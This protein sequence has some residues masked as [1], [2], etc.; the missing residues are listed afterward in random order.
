MRDLFLQ[1]VSVL[2]THVLLQDILAF[3]STFGHQVNATSHEA[4]RSYHC[5]QPQQYRLN[6]IVQK[7][8]G[9]LHFSFCFNHIDHLHSIVKSI[10]R[11]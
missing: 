1:L 5:H 9:L 10:R 6:H 7:L 4:L 2:L 8:H 3:L 11:C